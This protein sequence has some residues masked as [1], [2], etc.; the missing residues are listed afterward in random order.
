MNEALWV[1]RVGWMGGVILVHGVIGVLEGIFCGEIYRRIA[2]EMGRGVT[3][4]VI[5]PIYIIFDFR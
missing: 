5:L 2:R 3:V 4:I 1:W